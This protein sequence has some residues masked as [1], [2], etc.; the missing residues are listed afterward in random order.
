MVKGLITI[1]M[2]IIK[3]FS[4]IYLNIIKALCIPKED[5]KSTI[6]STSRA[7]LKLAKLCSHISRFFLPFDDFLPEREWAVVSW[8]S[9]LID[10]TVSSFVITL[11]LFLTK[12]VKR[13]VGLV[14][15]RRDGADGQRGVEVGRQ[16]RQC[17]RAEPAH[18]YAALRQLPKTCEVFIV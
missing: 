1:W 14:G 9:Q 11:N 7:T 3:T 17:A 2:C 15:L 18:G 10:R 4:S 16:L 5:Y 13:V 12:W 6:H 8:W